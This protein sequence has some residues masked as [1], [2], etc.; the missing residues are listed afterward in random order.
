[1]RERITTTEA[2]AKEL[3][4]HIDQLINKGKRA[5]V[6]DKAKRQAVLRD[7]RIRLSV[8]ATQKISGEF[9]KR[10]ETRKSGYV[11]VVK[12]DARKGDGAKMAVIEFV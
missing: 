11:R 1:M 12:L 5:A 7:L 6:A 9:A 2:K 3:K 4:N 8:E 10:F